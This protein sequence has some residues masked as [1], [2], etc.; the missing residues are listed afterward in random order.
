[1]DARRVIFISDD[2]SLARVDAGSEDPAQTLLSADGAQAIEQG[3]SFAWP[4]PSPR[5]DSVLVSRTGRDAEGALELDLLQVDPQSGEVRATLFRNTT[6]GRK[7][8]A[9]GLPHYAS[10][11]P[12]ARW[13][14]VGARS[15]ESLALTLVA[16]RKRVPGRVLLNGAPLFSAWAPDSD[17]IAVHAGSELLLL[18]LEGEDAP[19]RILRDQP[20]FRAP[21]WS[22]SGDGLYYVAPGSG[23]GDL[24]W[25]SRPDGGD[26][27]VVAELDG[28]TILHPCPA[29]DELALLTLA[30]G[31][32]GV[33]LRLLDPATGAVRRIERG[34]VQGA[35]WAPD[36][37]SLYYVTSAGVES[38]L[39]LIRYDLSD[40]RRLRLV[41]FRPSPAYLTYLAFFDQY[42]QSHRLISQD[43]RSMLVAGTVNSNGATSRRSF[44]P[45][46]GVSIVP[47]DGSGPPARSDSSPQPR[48][49]PAEAYHGSVDGERLSWVADG[50]HRVLRVVD[51]HAGSRLRAAPYQAARG[52]YRSAAALG[53]TSGGAGDPARGARPASRRQRQHHLPNPDDS[54]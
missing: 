32:I 19:Q 17:S 13:A 50:G 52:D 34:P 15:E 47:T 11:S 4:V 6:G 1:V 2:Q 43:G 21:A 30:V 5:G 29:G 36:G 3:H 33:D 48:R 9:P 10:W 41:R 35:L 37:S 40:G 46:Q 14:V 31:P 23:G 7:L 18:N 12:N 24:L 22:Q 51:R 8:I 38:D 54:A 28:F 53:E 16:N 39:A 27:E 26:R 44:G 20:R 49:N 45:Q 42:A 25:R